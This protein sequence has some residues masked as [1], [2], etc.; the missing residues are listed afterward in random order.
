MELENQKEIE[1]L[2]A[3]YMKRRIMPPKKIFDAL[4]VAFAVTHKLDYLVSWNF[5][6]LANVNRGKKIIAVNSESNYL[7]PIRIITPIELI[8]YGN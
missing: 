4:Y 2:A 7:P 8:D 3:Q 6:H 1:H 5:K